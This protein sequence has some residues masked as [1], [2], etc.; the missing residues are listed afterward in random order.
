MRLIKIAGIVWGIIYFVIGAVFSFTL[1]GRDFWSGA[2]VYVA[3]FFLP[4]PIAVV[5]VRFPRPAAIALI[6]SATVSVAVSVVSIIS[7][8]ARPD[9]AGLC[10]FTMYHVPHIVFA[11]AYFKASRQDR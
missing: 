9:L 5:A 8:G 7:Q 1:G 4:L 10:K 3:L 11:L 6:V 2:V